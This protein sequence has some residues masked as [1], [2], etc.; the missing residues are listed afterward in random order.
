VPRL[1]GGHPQGIAIPRGAEPASMLG[2]VVHAVEASANAEAWPRRPGG[3]LRTRKQPRTARVYF[4]C[5]SLVPVPSSSSET[6]ASTM[7]DAEK[8]LP[9]ILAPHLADVGKYLEGMVP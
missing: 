1:G 9:P 3:P 8:A 2:H 4:R 5:R 6:A 7:D